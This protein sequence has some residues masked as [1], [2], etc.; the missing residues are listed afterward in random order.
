MH[1]LKGE[2][3]NCR[4]MPHRQPCLRQGNQPALS[5]ISPT[6]CELTDSIILLRGSVQTADG[7]L[8]G[9]NKSVLPDN[10]YLRLQIA[11]GW[12]LESF[13]SAAK[14]ALDTGAVDVTSLQNVAHARQAELPAG[15]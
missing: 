4:L 14:A 8:V 10:K 5:L 13:T 15:L 2:T 1:D 12:P 7:P 11:L 3:K 9:Q 6:A